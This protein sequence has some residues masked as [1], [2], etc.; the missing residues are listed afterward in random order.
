MGISDLGQSCQRSGALNSLHHR[1]LRR[2][3]PLAALAASLGPRN[4][5]RVIYVQIGAKVGRASTAP[6]RIRR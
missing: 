1:D 2:L 3:P 6:L 5:V 4:G